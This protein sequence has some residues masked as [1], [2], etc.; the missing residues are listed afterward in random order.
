MRAAARIILIASANGF[1]GAVLSIA[2]VPRLIPAAA[3]IAVGVMAAT[4]ILLRKAAADTRR[5]DAE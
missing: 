1:F 2:I 5:E 4:W 3:A